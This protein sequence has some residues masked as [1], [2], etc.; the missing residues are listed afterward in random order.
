MRINHKVTTTVAVSLLLLSVACDRK[1]GSL[2][3]GQT[4]ATQS[5]TRY[6]CPMHPQVLSEKKESCAICGMHLVPITPD[7]APPSAGHVP[8]RT[9]VQVAPDSA[10]LI[11]VRTTRVEMRPMMV[12][13]RSGAK[14]T[15]DPILFSLLQQYRQS[16]ADLRAD[17]GAEPAGDAPRSSATDAIV[18]QLAAAGITKEDLQSVHRDSSSA[19]LAERRMLL[20]ISIQP[21]DGGMVQKG[22]RITATP[23]YVSGTMSGVVRNVLPPYNPFNQ[24]FVV[25]AELANPKGLIKRDMYVDVAIEI[26]LGTRLAIPA[27]AVIH[28]GTRAV[29]YTLTSPDIFEPREIELGVK[30]EN[31][32]EVVSGLGEG[33]EVVAAGTFLLDSESQLRAAH[34]P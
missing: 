31:F 27:D 7:R 28:T 2:T 5:Q 26:D 23:P 6:T 20:T 10:K 33:D 34:R 32:Y 11:G 1:E 30:A 22:Q 8:G 29:V 18:Q 17:D 16:S 12:I 3:Q 4:S 9:T 15:I 21:P 24:P 19:E 25:T 14:A 13:V